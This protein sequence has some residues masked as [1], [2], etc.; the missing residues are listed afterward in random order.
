MSLINDALRR[1]KQENKEPA[2]ESSDGSPMQPVH[3]SSSDKSSPLRAILMTLI[4]LMLLVAALLFWKGLQ[5]KKELA[6]AHARDAQMVLPKDISDSWTT[7]NKNDFQPAATTTQAVTTTLTHD[8]NSTRQTNPV[9]TNASVSS[10]STNQPIA[11]ASS[12]P[13]PL[14]LQGIFYRPSNPT[15]MINGKTVA[16]GEIVQ[17]ANVLK[18]E[19]QQV[20]LERNGKTEVLTME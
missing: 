16:V 3:P 17:G 15:A 20:T 10:I 8:S 12:E 2:P 6:A 18:I 13:P 11:V 9:P 5:T 14:K 1:K 7:T 19:R 4:V